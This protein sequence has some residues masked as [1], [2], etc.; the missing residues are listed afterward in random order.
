MKTIP[1]LVA[2]V[3]GISA[4]LVAQNL[5]QAQESLWT[6]YY[7]LRVKDGNIEDATQLVINSIIPITLH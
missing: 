6:P 1:V 7:I 3:V 2:I 4:C 5:P